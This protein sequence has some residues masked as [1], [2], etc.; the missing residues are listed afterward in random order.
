MDVVVND[1]SHNSVTVAIKDKKTH[2][3]LSQEYAI[4]YNTVD[5]SFFLLWDLKK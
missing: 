2:E 3:S 5:V 1:F 4:R